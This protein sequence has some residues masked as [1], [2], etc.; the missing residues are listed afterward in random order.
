MIAAVPA[1]GLPPAARADGDPASDVLLSQPLFLPQ[2]AGVPATEQAQLASLLAAAHRAGYNLR[3]ALIA[4]PAD[5]GSV[6]ALWHQPED[7]ARFLGQEL[8]LNY[9]GA[10]LVVMPGGYGFYRPHGP[11]T[12]EQSALNQLTPP[13]KTLGTGALSAIRRL[14]AAAGHNLP[15]PTTATPT[16]RSSTD[17]LEW[18]VFA[19][20]MLLIVVA[21]TASLRARPPRL[22]GGGSSAG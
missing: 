3:V 7:Y 8:S 4:G 17:T 10:V 2:D 13:G 15:A 5:L 12:S 21:W 1:G 16:S 18:I 6:T 22:F 20:G 9:T 19:I 11:S 14:A